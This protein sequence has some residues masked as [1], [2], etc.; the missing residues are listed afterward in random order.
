MLANN[1]VDITLM[2]PQEGITCSRLLV[3][4]IAA[5]HYRL[6]ETPLLIEGAKYGDVVKLE[7]QPDGTFHFLSVIEPS[8]WRV[9]DYILSKAVIESIAF[10]DLLSAVIAQGGDWEQFFGGCILIYLP[11]DAP[12]QPNQAIEAIYKS[13]S[14]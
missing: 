9:H 1:Q 11:P 4:H 6:D 12:C 2:F 7:L 8:T 13:L 14:R 3:T 5:D 10:Q